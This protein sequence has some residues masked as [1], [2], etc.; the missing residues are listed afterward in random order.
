MYFPGLSRHRVPR[1]SE[2]SAAM[3]T[4]YCPDLGVSNKRNQGSLEKWQKAGA[5]AGKT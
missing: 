5:W 4:S 1:S 3:S 2:S